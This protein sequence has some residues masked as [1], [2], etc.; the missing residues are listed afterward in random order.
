MSFFN[1]VH[2]GPQN[3]FKAKA[4]AQ[5]NTDKDGFEQD[6]NTES[7]QD[8]KK[9]QANTTASPSQP[10]TSQKSWHD[11]SHVVYKDLI[12]KHRRNPNGTCV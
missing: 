8:Q 12:R 10:L 11:G 7:L 1:L 3:S 5:N 2:L 4:K 9:P 6:N